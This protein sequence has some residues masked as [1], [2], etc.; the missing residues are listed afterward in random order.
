MLV[1]AVY[2]NLQIYFEG[3]RSSTFN[4]ANQGWLVVFFIQLLKAILVFL[5][6]S[7]CPLLYFVPGCGQH[8]SNLLL[9]LSR[10]VFCLLRIFGCF[11]FE[12]RLNIVPC[13]CVFLARSHWLISNTHTTCYFNQVWRDLTVLLC[14]SFTP[15]TLIA[16]YYILV[17]L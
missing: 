13:M 14:L 12:L 5:H 7:L 2:S 8:F 1:T 9:A 17:P 3:P 15:I 16:L 6:P 4:M 10:V 11:M